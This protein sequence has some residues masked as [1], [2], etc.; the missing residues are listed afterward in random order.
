MIL[1]GG[2]CSSRS[3]VV[4]NCVVSSLPGKR[5][6]FET[7]CR[8]KRR[9]VTGKV[10]T[11]TSVRLRDFS[12]KD[13]A[14][15]GSIV[16]IPGSF[17]AASF[18]P[19]ATQLFPDDTTVFRTPRPGLSISK[20]ETILRSAV[21]QFSWVQPPLRQS[22]LCTCSP[23]FFSLFCTAAQNFAQHSD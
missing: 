4:I 19:P 16:V 13:R 22:S 12:I 11:S 17:D 23:E 8:A 7:N 14:L 6:E 20:L 3:S 15:S 5:H 18:C 9:R 21:R 10:T 1:H 2:R